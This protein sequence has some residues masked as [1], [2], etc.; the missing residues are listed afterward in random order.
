MNDSSTKFQS[1]ENTEQTESL[2]DVGHTAADFVPTGAR[3]MK[4]IMMASVCSA[5][6]KALR[7]EKNVMRKFFAQNQENEQ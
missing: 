4:N 7:V 5:V 3:R 1:T 2:A 6:V